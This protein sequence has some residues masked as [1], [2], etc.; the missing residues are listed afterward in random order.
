M[1]S[2]QI[3]KTT[4]HSCDVG[5]C[6]NVR[7]WN[8]L[9]YSDSNGILMS[10]LTSNKLKPLIP[11]SPD[12]NFWNVTINGLWPSCSSQSCCGQYIDISTSFCVTTLPVYFL[13]YLLTNCTGRLTPKEGLHIRWRHYFTRNISKY[14][15]DS[16][17]FFLKHVKDDSYKRNENI[18]R[19]TAQSQNAMVIVTGN[20]ATDVLY[21]V[22][23]VIHTNVLAGFFTEY[24]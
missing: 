16:M 17:F 10:M 19:Y 2:L 4:S 22:C 13:F 20:L 18:M 23:T 5:L 21:K 3:L 9:R 8:L 7:R 24:P 11:Q 14:S 15:V 6:R 12:V 1:F